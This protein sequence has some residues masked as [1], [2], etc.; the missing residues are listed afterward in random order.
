M[1]ELINRGNVIQSGDLLFDNMLNNIFGS[2]HNTSSDYYYSNDDKCH[3]VELALPGLNKK[4]INLTINDNYLSLSYDPS[5]D[6]KKSIWNKSFNR[7]IKL[8]NNIKKDGV[9][10][11]LKDGIL[12]IKIEKVNPIKNTKVIE[13]K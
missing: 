8:P 9:S 1:F 10:A 3:Y 11:K 12:S 5:E 6:D 2:I 4:D 13:I 7:K